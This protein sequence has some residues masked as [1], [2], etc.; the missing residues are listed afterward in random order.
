[1]RDQEQIE[2]PGQLA[3]RFSRELRELVEQGE[4]SPSLARRVTEDLFTPGEEGQPPRL[5]WSAWRTY[6]AGLT[7]D[8]G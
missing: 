6:V 3:E 8:H 1:M 5:R 7:G 4:I 2:T